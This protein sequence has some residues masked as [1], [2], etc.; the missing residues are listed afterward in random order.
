MKTL[1]VLLTAL[2]FSAS[3]TF[4]T[5]IDNSI[6]KEAKVSVNKAVSF[7]LSKQNE[8]CSWGPYGGMPAFTAIVINSLLTSPEASSSR[9]K[10]A[11]AK[12][13]EIEAKK[14]NC[15]ICVTR[16]GNVMFSRGSLIPFLINKIKKN[17]ELT[18]TDPNM[19]RFLM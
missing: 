18:L 8:N 19:T 12:A 7:L 9:V 14:I 13:R 5:G 3:T 11:I 15:S 2:F 1:A 16:Y 10:V 17:E 6:L 4:A